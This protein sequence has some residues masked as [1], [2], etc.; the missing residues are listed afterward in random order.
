MHGRY[1]PQKPQMSRNPIFGGKMDFGFAQSDV[2]PNTAFGHA[3]QANTVT[4]L[5]GDWPQ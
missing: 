4:A 2:S 5:R 3:R 1:R